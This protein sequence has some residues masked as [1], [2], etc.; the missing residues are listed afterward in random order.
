MNLFLPEKVSVWCYRALIN[1]SPF[2]ANGTLE[3]VGVQNLLQVIVFRVNVILLVFFLSVSVFLDLP[4]MAY[5]TSFPHPDGS[6]T[7]LFKYFCLS[8]LK[9]VVDL[10]KLLR[11]YCHG[12]LTERTLVVKGVQPMTRSNCVMLAC[13]CLGRRGRSSSPG[14][15]GGSEGDWP[16]LWGSWEEGRASGSL[17]QKCLL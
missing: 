10:G 15:F 2:L 4:S 1:T 5:H 12:W 9:N 11:Q 17:A 14:H 13:L 16:K 6:E 3:Q 7:L 8:V